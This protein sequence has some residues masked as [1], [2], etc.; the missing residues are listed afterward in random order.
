MIY[1]FSEKHNRSVL[2]FESDEERASFEKDIADGMNNKSIGEKYGISPYSIPRVA[3]RHCIDL[4]GIRQR[5]YEKKC[6]E[7]IRLYVEGNS[8][9]KIREI[10]HMSE[11]TVANIINYTYTDDEKEDIKFNRES[12]GSDWHPTPTADPNV[13]INDFGKLKALHNAGWS[14]EKIADEFGVTIQEVER[15]LEL[16]NSK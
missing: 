10:M 2:T 6:D 9:D 13:T 3:E 8:I 15:C 12:L 5:N 16:L 14:I 11:R 1:R 4:Y 7:I